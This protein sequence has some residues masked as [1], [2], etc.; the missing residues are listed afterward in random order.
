MADWEVRLV[1]RFYVPH[2]CFCLW[3]DCM[4]C[5]IRIVVWWDICFTCLIP[6]IIL[7][8]IDICYRILPRFTGFTRFIFGS[9]CRRFSSLNYNWKKKNTIISNFIEFQKENNLLDKEAPCSCTVDDPAFHFSV[10][11]FSFLLQFSKDNNNFIQVSITYSREAGRK[12]SDRG[13]QKN[14][15]WRTE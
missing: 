13:W 6:W 4:I 7:N 15:K 8:A 5:S 9:E 1:V 3:L 10:F 12:K 14:T 2:R 11:F